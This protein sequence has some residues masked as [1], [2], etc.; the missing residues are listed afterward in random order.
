MKTIRTVS[1]P[2][3]TKKASVVGLIE[4]LILGS[5]LAAAVIYFLGNNGFINSSDI[6]PYPY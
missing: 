5:L 6:Q 4:W 1:V 3:Q 2:T